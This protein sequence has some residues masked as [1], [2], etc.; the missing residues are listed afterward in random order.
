MEKDQNHFT[1]TGTI[2]TVVETAF[3][4]YLLHDRPHPRKKIIGVKRTVIYKPAGMGLIN[5]L[6]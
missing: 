2:P 5:A 4:L 6:A 3:F 1:A